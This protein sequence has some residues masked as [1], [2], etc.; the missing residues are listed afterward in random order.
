MTKKWKIFLMWLPVVGITWV[1]Y[2]L[3]GK[4]HKIY[5]FYQMSTCIIALA[6][7]LSI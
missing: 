7:I 1:D 3:I 5:G 6:I 2:D 4:N